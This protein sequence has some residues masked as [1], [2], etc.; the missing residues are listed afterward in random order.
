M[1]NELCLE[2][3]IDLLKEIRRKGFFEFGRELALIAKD[4]AWSEIFDTFKRFCIN[5][6]DLSENKGVLYINSVYAVMNIHL[7]RQTKGAD[8]LDAKSIDSIDWEQVPY[9]FEMASLL[10]GYTP[11]VQM[12]LWDAARMIAANTLQEVVKLKHLRK[13]IK[14]RFPK[15]QPI[16]LPILTADDVAVHAVQVI[17]S[18]PADQD[19]VVVANAMEA[20]LAQIGAIDA[21][22]K[23][24]EL[25]GRKLGEKRNKLRQND[26]QVPTLGALSESGHIVQLFPSGPAMAIP[27]LSNI[28]E[29]AS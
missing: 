29:G 18:M 20:L 8:L 27:E 15:P 19:M 14:L 1:S 12:E 24:I 11:D 22:G 3:R 17:N 26:T 25:V 16:Q 4:Q 28:Q 7:G 21:R 9:T 5:A 2:E 6:L 10:A 13:A 23:L